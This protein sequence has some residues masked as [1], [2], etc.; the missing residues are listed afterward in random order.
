MKVSVDIWLQK[1]PFISD[2]LGLALLAISAAILTR[3]P[4]H[5]PHAI[6]LFKEDLAEIGLLRPRSFWQI[7]GPVSFISP[8][9]RCL[10]SVAYELLAYSKAMIA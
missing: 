1:D 10:L 7:N 9:V 2:N 5:I 4:P 6:I 3:A 8:A